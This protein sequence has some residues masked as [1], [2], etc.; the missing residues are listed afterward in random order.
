MLATAATF[1]KEMV[2]GPNGG[3]PL[4]YPFEYIS[5]EEIDKVAQK[6]AKTA[7]AD[8]F[9]DLDCPVESDTTLSGVLSSLSVYSGLL[10]DIPVSVCMT[11]PDGAR[12]FSAIVRDGHYAVLVEFPSSSVTALCRDIQEILVQQ[13]KDVPIG[14]AVFYHEKVP[15]LELEPAQ[16]VSTPKEKRRTSKTK[17]KKPTKRSRAPTTETEKTAE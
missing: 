13:Q 15:P 12:G 8:V 16:P 1:C 11:S 2:A 9:R 14:K 7:T 10:R 3:L 4:S 5:T 6:C 17:T